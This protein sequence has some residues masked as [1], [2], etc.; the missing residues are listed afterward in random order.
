MSEVEPTPDAPA[1]VAPEAPVEP[2]AAPSDDVGGESLVV[3][4]GGPK[5]GQTTTLPGHDVEEFTTT[6]GESYQRSDEQEGNFRVYR[7]TGEHATSVITAT[8]P[9]PTLARDLAELGL[10]TTAEEQ[11]VA[12]LQADVAPVEPETPA[13]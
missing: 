7:F 12:A 8:P 9:M 5:D 2:V 10:T 4:R 13:A 3:L 11:A 6:D 1:D